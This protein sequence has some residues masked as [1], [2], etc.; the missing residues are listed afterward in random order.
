VPE[1]VDLDG[2]T[3]RCVRARELRGQLQEAP[4]G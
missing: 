4:D 3:S 2:G 1:L